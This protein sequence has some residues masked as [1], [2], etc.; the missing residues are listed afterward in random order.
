MNINEIE[1]ALFNMLDV[2]KVVS[3]NPK[4]WQSL[5]DNEGTECTVGDCIEDTIDFLEQLL[6]NQKLSD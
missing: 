1:N 6:S 2:K 3:N 4:V 5:K